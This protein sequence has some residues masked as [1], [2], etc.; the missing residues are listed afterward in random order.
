MKTTRWLLGLFLSAATILRAAEVNVGD[1]RATV[2]DALGVPRGQVNLAGRQVLYYERGEVELTGERVTRVALRTPEEQEALVA[3]EERQRGAREARMNEL[4]AAGVALRDRK[5]AD[6][7]FKSSPLG[8]QVSF[9]QNFARSY[10]GV[11]ISEPFTIA[12]MRYA[13]QLE[14]RRRK[15]E[16]AARV[17]A[18]E[19]QLAE[20]RSRAGYYPRYA[21][22][23]GRSYQ[24]FNLFRDVRYDFN[25]PVG[26]PYET[27]HG[28]PYETPHGSPYETPHGSPYET[29]HGSPYLTPSGNA[30]SPLSGPLADWGWAGRERY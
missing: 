30:A 15:D 11:S 23:Y 13:E 6:D 14:E 20:E 8:Y 28:S 9:W 12:R 17:A 1:N 22:Y 7:T 27:P 19:A 10:P 3:L 16:E 21:G 25:T 5:L 26:V 29:P 4:I 2:R 18:L 24:P